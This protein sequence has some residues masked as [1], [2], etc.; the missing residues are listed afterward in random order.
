MAQEKTAQGRGW[1]TG[2]VGLIVLVGLFFWLRYEFRTKVEVTAAQA[3]YQ[4]IVSTKANNGKVVPVDDFQA[5]APAP[6]TIAKLFVH[7]G[8]K[9]TK[10]E[11]L[12]QLDDSDARSKLASAQAGLVSSEATLGNMRSGGS[13]DEMLSQKADIDSAQ[14]QVQRDQTQLTV[15][16]SLLAKGAVSPN[17]VESARQ[18]LALDQAKLTQLQARRVD[19]YS[20]NDVATQ[21]AQIANAKSSVAAASNMLSQF[22]IR[23]PITGTVYSLPYSQYDFVGAGEA[24]LNVADLTKLQVKAYFDEPEVGVLQV[25]QPVTIAWDAKPDHVWHGHIK[26]VPQ[27]IVGYNLRNVGICIITV[28]DPTADLLPNTNV[29]VTVTTSET[30]HALTIPREGLRTQGDVNYV[31]R[32]V[33][34]HLKKTIVTVGALNLTQVQILSGLKENDTV[35][36]GTNGDEQ[37]TDGLEVKAQR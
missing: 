7:V 28:E 1:V 4:D 9:V 34:G 25:G 14:M 20:H 37:L 15:Q 16:Q 8:Q 22:D 12:L 29:T 6:A 11:V 24:L 17:E 36:I 5:Y 30:H 21:Q 32:V 23:S 35:A 26:Q 27:T 13:Q 10:G 18:K 33:D 3:T 19:R 2:L 31:F